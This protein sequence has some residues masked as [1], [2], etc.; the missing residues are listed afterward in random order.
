MPGEQEYFHGLRIVN[1]EA[2]I[3]KSDPR[4]KARSIVSSLRCETGSPY[5]QARLL[6]M[7]RW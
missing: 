5:V 4:D 7:R 3:R 2:W 6:E 1:D